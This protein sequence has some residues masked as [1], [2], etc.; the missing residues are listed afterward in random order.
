MNLDFQTWYE[1]Y[2]DEYAPPDEAVMTRIRNTPVACDNPPHLRGDCYRFKMPLGEKIV[3]VINLGSKIGLKA[4]NGSLNARC[5][6]LL[7]KK[8]YKKLFETLNY[9]YFNNNPMLRRQV[10][11]YKA[12]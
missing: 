9:V 7:E 8:D 10:I 2:D 11:Y 4:A 5:F 3:F 12:T 1:E 6:Q